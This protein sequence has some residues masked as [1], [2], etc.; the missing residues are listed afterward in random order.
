[1]AEPST[2]IKVRVALKMKP[3]TCTT[4]AGLDSERGLVLSGIDTG[5]L[6]VGDLMA[7]WLGAEA[8]QFLKD[9]Q[10]ELKPGRCVDLELFHIKPTNSEIRARVRS[11]A[12]A[13]K[14]PSWL[15]HEERAHQRNQQTQE[16]PA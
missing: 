3:A 8:T 2:S 7:Q 11:C 9:H 6:I 14:A 1:M 4:G 15:K 16:H 12:L 5:G 10:E 13:P